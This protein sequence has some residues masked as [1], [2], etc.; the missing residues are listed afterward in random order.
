MSFDVAYVRGLFPS[1]GDGWI[2][3]DPQAGM[4][5]PNSVSTAVS[6]GFR[7]FAAPPNPLYPS[8]R[9]SADVTDRARRAIADLVG[10]DPAG[11]V[12]GNSRFSLMSALT[13]SL[14]ASHKSVGDVVVSRTD[15]E[16]NIVPWLRLAKRSGW[17]P[18]WAE[19][20]VETGEL[21]AWQFEKL[22]TGPVSVVTVSM[23]SS[24]TGV[25]TDLEPIV[26]GAVHAR[27]LLVVDATSAAPFDTLDINEIGADVMVVSA[28]RW[29]GPPVAAMVFADPD[30]LNALES[31]SLD[32]SATGPAR[33]EPERVSGA[34][35]AGTVASVEYLANLDEEAKGKRRQRLTTAI[36]GQSEYLDRL[37]TY[38]RSTLENL[39]QV[40]V[41]GESANRVPL[42]SFTVANVGADKV[43]RR[44][45]D[46]GVRALTGIPSR[47]FDV[48]G[49][50][51][52]GGAVTIGLGPYSTPVEVDHLVRTLASLG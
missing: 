29:G 1:L 12:L 26:D 6:T 36:K 7:Q 48:M 31:V 32:P 8:G 9:A 5:I 37:L 47:A 51:D 42:L 17:S 45:A 2:H 21:P 23:A 46:N 22:L 39:N 43:V 28:Q 15:D 14:L 35:L 3:F 33:L 34:L 11:V 19:I 20:D 50:N 18:R 44:L 38:L 27:A 24:V 10:G 25:I 52:F 16:E 41:I 30:R 49:V 13:E 40:H 4:L